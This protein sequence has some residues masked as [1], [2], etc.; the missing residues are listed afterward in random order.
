[1][2]GGPNESTLRWLLCSGPWVHWNSRLLGVAPA[3]RTLS[4]W[5]LAPL[6][7]CWVGGDVD[8]REG[9]KDG[10]MDEGG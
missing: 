3:L 10:E 2:N 7:L 1:M 5:P 4:L 9:G 6:D 8:G